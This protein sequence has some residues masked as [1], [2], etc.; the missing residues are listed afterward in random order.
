MF[1]YKILRS[2][3]DHPYPDNVTDGENGWNY[4]QA[5]LD[6]L[7]VEGWELVSGFRKDNVSKSN[8]VQGIRVEAVPDRE[9]LFKREV[10]P[11]KGLMGP[12][13]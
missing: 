2:N 7:G 9:L 4:L 6:D 8:T 13:I 12:P 11:V 1:E 5:A 10:N 3:P